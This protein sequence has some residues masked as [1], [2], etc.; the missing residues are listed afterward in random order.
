MTEAVPPQITTTSIQETM[1]FLKDHDIYLSN[2]P[3]VYR[4]FLAKHC[5]VVCF[6]LVIRS[7]RMR[8]RGREKQQLKGC[9]R[10]LRIWESTKHAAA[11]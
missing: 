10:E 11:R 2:L 1:D 6:S 5:H 9:I 7:L 8:M 4:H 3:H